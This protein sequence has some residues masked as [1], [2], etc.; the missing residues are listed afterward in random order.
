M[1][2]PA[3]FDIS[4]NDAEMLEEQHR[5]M[6]RQ[7]EEEQQSLLRLQEAAEARHAE[8]VA[9]KARREAE[10]KA[11]EEAERQR[12]AE[13][14]ERKKRTR[15]YLQRLRDEVLE[16][17]ATLL[18]GAEGS[19]AAGSKRKEVAAGDEEEQWPSPRRLEGSNRG[20][21]TEMPQSRWGALPPVRGVCV[22]GRIAW[23][24]PQGE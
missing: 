1:S 15:E 18:E 2:S 23:C 16:E 22:P 10:A 6:Q 24:T 4:Q 13:E 19:Q 5:Q 7:H 11:K 21:A 14:E 20:S 12:V 9:Q 8:R 17:E 3:P